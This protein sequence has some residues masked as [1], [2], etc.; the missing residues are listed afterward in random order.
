MSQELITKAELIKWCDQQVK[1]GKELKLHW[2]GGG[3]SGWV[4]FTIDDKQLSNE[5]DSPKEVNELI[6]LMYNHLDYG[7]WAGEFNASGEAVYD[8]EEKAFV[9]IDNYSEDDTYHQECEIK[10]SVPKTL[11][12]DF[13]EYNLEGEEPSI[14]IAFIIRN[15][16]LTDEHDETAKNIVSHLEQEISKEITKYQSKYND[17]QEYRNI[18]QNDRFPRSAFVE[19]GDDLVYTIEELNIGTYDTQEK[20][21]Y[22]E[23]ITDEDE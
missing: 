1:E 2:E 10:I 6:E 7:S 21:V 14:D 9:G 15:G 5:A 12:F 16:F 4:Y 22:L 18:W 20:E 3:D 23:L 19:E 11:W 17:G 8:S 13:I